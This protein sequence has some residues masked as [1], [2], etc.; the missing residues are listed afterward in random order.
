MSSNG[1]L[2]V[3][4]SKRRV[5]TLVARNFMLGERVERERRQRELLEVLLRSALHQLAI[6]KGEPPERFRIRWMKNRY[7]EFL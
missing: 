6:A 5:E 4:L 2:V 7:E 3:M 1:V